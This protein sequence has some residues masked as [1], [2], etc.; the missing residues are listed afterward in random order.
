MWLEGSARRL[1]GAVRGKAV[2]V[3]TVSALYWLVILAGILAA[4]V[5]AALNA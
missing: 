3:R 2:A 5:A 1:T 4:V